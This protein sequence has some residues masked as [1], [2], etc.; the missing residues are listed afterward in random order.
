MI[1]E[2]IIDKTLIFL[3][4]L[5]SKNKPGYRLGA[6]RLYRKLSKYTNTERRV[7][8]D[9]S[10]QLIYLTIIAMTSHVLERTLHIRLLL[11]KQIKIP[12][13]SSI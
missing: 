10:S 5:Y 2:N 1:V 11:T 4:Y 7:K 8:Q 9:A 12:E 13:L 6:N 3:N